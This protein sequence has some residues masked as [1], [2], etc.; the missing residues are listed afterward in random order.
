MTFF[1]VQHVYDVTSFLQEH[2]GGDEVL[3]EQAG[4]DATESFKDIGHSRD[5]VEMT[6]EY[7]IGY[8]SDA[9]AKEAAGDKK[10]SAAPVI[11]KKAESWTDIMCS[12]TWSNFLIPLAISGLVYFLYRVIAGV[13]TVTCV[14][15]SPKCLLE[16]LLE[17]R[18]HSTPYKEKS[19][20][21]VP[22]FFKNIL[23][24]K[25]HFC[26]KVSLPRSHLT[27]SAIV[28]SAF[29]HLLLP[30]SPYL[31]QTSGMCNHFPRNSSIQAISEG[32]CR[33]TYTPRLINLFL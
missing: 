12:P 32:T 5:A 21:D 23:A 1:S 14:Q 31:P 8:L 11:S 19:L 33:T 10:K 6:K 20:Q 22:N 30:L 18:C 28:H 16:L 7:L 2:P 13:F 26:L 27:L 9:S 15:L 17:A 24:K 4:R 3:L 25:A 29:H